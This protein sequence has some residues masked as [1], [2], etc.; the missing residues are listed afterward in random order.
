MD[1]KSFS[2]R[3]EEFRYIHYGNGREELYDHTNDPFE[4]HNVADQKKYLK[5]KKVLRSEMKTIIED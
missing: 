3:T 2:Y 5:T 4:W 1:C